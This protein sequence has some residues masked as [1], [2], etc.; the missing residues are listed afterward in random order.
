MQFIYELPPKNNVRQVMPF[1]LYALLQPLFRILH[2]ENCHS[3]SLSATDVGRPGGFLFHDRPCCSKRFDPSQYCV[4]IR[5][6][7]KAL[8]IKLC[9]ETALNCDYGLCFNISFKDKHSMFQ[10]PRHQGT[11]AQ[12]K[13]STNKRRKSPL[14]SLSS[15]SESKN[16]HYS[17]APCISHQ[18]CKTLFETPYII[19]RYIT[20]TVQVARQLP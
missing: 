19:R 1:L 4:T 18:S 20:C 9:T 10:G 3:H 7:S 6:V 16:I 2:S 11:T 5:D 8:Q 14:F 13:L 15:T 17:A 12:S